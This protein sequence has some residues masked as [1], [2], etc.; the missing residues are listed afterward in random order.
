ME[1]TRSSVDGEACV[2]TITEQ[3]SQVFNFKILVLPNRVQSGRNLEK[4]VLQNDPKQGTD[5][6]EIACWSLNG[7]IKEPAIVLSGKPQKY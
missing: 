7:N 2:F 3:H 6:P 1:T 4:A 5:K